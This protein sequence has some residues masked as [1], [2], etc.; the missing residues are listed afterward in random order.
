MENNQD[1]EAEDT[2]NKAN[3]NGLNKELEKKKLDLIE[4]LNNTAL[5]E[6][7]LDQ[8]KRMSEVIGNIFYKSMKNL[9]DTGAKLAKSLTREFLPET[10]DK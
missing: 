7:S 6:K 5:N 4:E 9:F 1:S 10:R 2:E 8:S 3:L